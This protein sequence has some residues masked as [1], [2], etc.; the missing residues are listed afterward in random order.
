MRI[1]KSVALVVSLGI[2]AASG[3]IIGPTKAAPV[4]IGVEG[5]GFFGDVLIGED[6]TLPFTITITPFFAPS[7]SGFQ[8]F[9]EYSQVLGACAAE[10]SARQS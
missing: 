3:L 7:A 2:I 6:L 5:T 1:V 4:T 9:N 8:E 10:R